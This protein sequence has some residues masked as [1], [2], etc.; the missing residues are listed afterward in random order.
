M[1]FP[2]EQADVLSN[3]VALGYLSGAG[4]AQKYGILIFVTK[5]AHNRWNRWIS[6]FLTSD[7]R[8]RYICTVKE[9]RKDRKITEPQSVAFYSDF[10]AMFHMR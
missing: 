5:V 9:N 4:L 3:G 1:G 7:A 2:C 8:V 10:S 6:C